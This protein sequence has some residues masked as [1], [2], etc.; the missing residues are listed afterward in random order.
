MKA[1][2]KIYWIGGMLAAL[3]LVIYFLN[4]ARTEVETVKIGEGQIQRAVVDTGYVQSSSAT[5]LYSDQGGRVEKIMVSIGQA[6]KRGQ[7]IM[8]LINT[9]ITVQTD[10]TKLQLAQTQAAVSAAEASVV[11]SKLDLDKTQKD[12]ERME[13]LLAAGAASQAEYDAT[14][15]LLDKYQQNYQQQVQNLNMAREQGSVMAL[16]LALTGE[17]VFHCPSLIIPVMKKASW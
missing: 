17:M 10:Q 1:G 6:V 3:V 14:R 16:L 13:K 2:K 9:D 15:L 7:V 12:L 5:D 8:T 11:N 4:T